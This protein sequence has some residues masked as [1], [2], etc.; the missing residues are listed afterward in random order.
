MYSS[1]FEPIKLAAVTVPNRIVRA[2]HGVEMD[3]E[4]TLAYHEARARGGVGLSM[5]GVIVTED[6]DGAYPFLERMADVH[7]LYGSRIFRQL[8][9]AGSDFPP[10]AGSV[11]YSASDVP[12]PSVGIVPVAMTKQ[13]IAETVESFAR[14]AR[15]TADAGMDGIEIHAAHGKLL[16]QFLSPALNHRDD[17]YGGCPENRV[18]FL[19][20][21]IGAVREQV[22][23]DYPV[24]VRLSSEDQVRGGL[25]VEQTVQIARAIQSSVDFIDVTFG[26]HW[27]RHMITGTTEVPHGYQVP[28]SEVVTAA[29]QVPTIVTGRILT[30][31]QA[32]HLVSSGV[33][34]MVSMV[35]ALI[36][37][38]GLVEK[39]RDGRQAEIRP[40]IGTTVGCLGGVMSG[41]GFGCVVNLAAGKELEVPFEPEPAHDP[42]R[43][44]VVGGGPAGLEAARAAALRGHAV[45]LHELTGH[46]GGQVS[47]AA[48]APHRAD[49]GVIT[50]WLSEE[51]YRLGVEVHLRSAVEPDL[52]AAARPDE[53]IVATGS[54]PRRDFQLWRPAG[55][56]PGSQLP[57]VFTSWELFGFGG[58]ARIGS[59][60]VVYDDTGTFEAIS[61]A[62]QL[63][64][65]GAAVKFVSRLDAPGANIPAPVMTVGG[66]RERLMSGPFEIFGS[67]YIERITPESVEVTAR[68]T[69][70]TRTLAADTVVIVGYNRLNRE[71]ADTLSSSGWNVHVVGDAAGGSTIME[72]LHQG[73]SVA[74]SI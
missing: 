47:I 64:E 44:L 18:R 55:P 4:A 51:L 21:V 67:S 33:A 46:L 36:A 38:P 17:E 45:E 73:A 60:A 61:V 41:R 12:D 69:D 22:G 53:V 40:C 28:T 68:G 3:D 15:R 7:H 29:V 10:R 58:R 65:Q 39:A 72:A 9:G 11:V 50:G 30:L 27:R 32:D 35:R 52:I 56:I 14:A 2:A 74:R 20:E 43:V 34:D 13:M 42:K 1:L 57:H 19:V 62:D 71:L 6:H 5:L 66:S 25:D 23:G 24:G 49:V 48:A 37:D 8:M 31:D 16:Q 59:S 70:R 26:G 54:I 63:I